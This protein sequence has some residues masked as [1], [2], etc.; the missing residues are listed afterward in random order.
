MRPD[1]RDMRAGST[2][3]MRMLD[4]REQMRLVGG[5]MRGDPRGKENY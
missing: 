2:D 3:P 4:P 5:D 1:P